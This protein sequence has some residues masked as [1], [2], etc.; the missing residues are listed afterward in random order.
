MNVNEAATCIQSFKDREAEQIQTEIYSKL[1][2]R[3]DGNKEGIHSGTSR[4]VT[5][6]ELH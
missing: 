6:A 2:I 1:G 3:R 5:L 4:F